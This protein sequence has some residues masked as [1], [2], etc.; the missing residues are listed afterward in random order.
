VDAN[1]RVDL[2]GLGVVS[3]ILHGHEESTL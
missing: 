3:S 2:V 1:S